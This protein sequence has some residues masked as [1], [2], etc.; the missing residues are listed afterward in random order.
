MRRWLIALVALVVGVVLFFQVN[1]RY[2]MIDM[3]SLDVSVSPGLELDSVQIRRG[4]YSIDRTNDGELFSG[5]VN[6]R[7]VFDGHQVGLLRTD[8]GENDFLIIYGQ[9]N[10]FQ[11]RHF[12]T[13]SNHQHDYQIRLE[14][15]ADSI[16]VSATI[17]G[18]ES[19]RFSRPMSAVTAAGHL[20]CNVPTDSSKVIYNM[21]ELE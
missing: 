1:R 11:F 8:Y 7:V 2:K 17:D 13:N 9:R 5:A 19:M 6:D 15:R 20:K 21:L 4:F 10:Y 14:Q 16:V 3:S 12:L 18:P